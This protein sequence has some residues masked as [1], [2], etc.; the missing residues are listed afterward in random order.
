M[1][2]LAILLA[3]YNSEKYLRLQLESVLNQ[4]YTDWTLYIRDDGSK[5]NTLEIVREYM[6]K[7]DRLKLLHDEVKG[8]GAKNSFL[9]LLEHTDS[10]YYM[11]CDHDDVWFTEKIK[12]TM[13]RMIA[14]ESIYPMVP[15]VV[16][17]DL[18]VTDTDLKPI[19]PS[20]WEYTRL[21]AIVNDM[22]MIPVNNVVTGCTMLINNPAKKISFPVH[23]NALMH[24]SW[25][26]LC[27]LSNKGIVSALH[28]TTMF[29]RQHGSNTLGAVK[30]NNSLSHRLTNLKKSLTLNI[31]IYRIANVTV[32]Y[33]ILE[34]L[35]YKIL[36]LHAIMTYT[37][38]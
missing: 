24:D 26:T 10:I 14:L 19:S 3:T 4:S 22:R 31:Q 7:D 13:E 11:F 23:P 37:N 34:Y 17:T 30:Y 5:D 35:K 33:N 8:R 15:I 16:H 12:V 28:S 20:F 9:W 29:Y 1:E 18:V 36:C 25:I 6:Q 32:G 2:N 38:R 27:V 21:N